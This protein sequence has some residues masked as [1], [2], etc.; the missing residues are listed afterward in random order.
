MSTHT[1]RA[2]VRY[3][4]VL[5][6]VTSASSDGVAS[7]GQDWWQSEIW[8]FSLSKSVCVC[9][10]WCVSMCVCERGN[11]MRQPSRRWPH[12]DH[13]SSFLFLTFQC[14]RPAL[15]H[16]YYQ[17]RCCYLISIPSKCCVWHSVRNI[18][19]EILI[20]L[21]LNVQ[22]LLC[23]WFILKVLGVVQCI[24]STH[25]HAMASMSEM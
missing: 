24:A 18:Q 3:Q 15:I 1:F 25:G 19:R 4:T 14:L 8:G 17:P 9:G 22:I 6:Q 7:G 5:V 20:F 23:T 10:C 2:V 16:V 13:I 12:N 11:V 21:N